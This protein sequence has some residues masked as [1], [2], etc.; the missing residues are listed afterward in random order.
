MG[1]GV[2][3]YRCPVIPFDFLPCASAAPPSASSPSGFCTL[4]GC[5]SMSDSSF[6]V[7]S[8]GWVGGVFAVPL[9][10][11][12]CAVLFSGP[13]ACAAFPAA[14]SLGVFRS[15]C[16]PG[17]VDWASALPFFFCASLALLACRGRRGYAPCVRVLQ[18]Q[19]CLLGL[20]VRSPCCPSLT[21]GWVCFWPKVS[22][23]FVG[24]E[25]S[26]SCPSWF[27]TAL[28]SWTAY[29]GRWMVQVP[30]VF[31][32]LT[33]GS[34][35]SLP[36]LAAG[37]RW[38]RFILGCPP[39]VASLWRGLT[40]FF[41]RYWLACPHGAAVPLDSWGRSPISGPSVFFLS[42]RPWRCFPSFG[43]VCF[44][45][46]CG[47]TT[48]GWCCRLWLVL[49]RTAVRPSHGSVLI[50]HPGFLFSGLVERG[51]FHRVSSLSSFGMWSPF[52]VI[53]VFCHYWS[54]TKVAIGGVFLL[55]GSLPFSSAVVVSLRPLSV[56]HGS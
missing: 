52:G 1:L 5:V 43:W 49:V 17:D 38:L 30:A 39:S 51:A 15:F 42:P 56:C 16:F 54:P 8:W 26:L 12:P 2:S 36:V 9:G 55:C 25:G 10:F 32:N 24:C 50:L 14:G 41:I 13:A 33:L 28:G 44:W 45:S 48:S 22:Q 31:L 4:D 29:F 19:W 40:W 21:L 20:K 37:L 6:L 47:S 23:A 46:S 34:S 7:Y 27:V 53:S 35:L 3:W 18:L 11:L